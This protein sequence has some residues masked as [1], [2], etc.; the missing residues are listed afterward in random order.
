MM[1]FVIDVIR[2][3][4]YAFLGLGLRLELAGMIGSWLINYLLGV[5]ALDDMIKSFGEGVHFLKWLSTG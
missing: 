5:F 2:G 4:E 3:F 1:D